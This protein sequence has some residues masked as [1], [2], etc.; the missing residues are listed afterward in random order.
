M[1]HYW[2]NAAFV[3]DD[4]LLRNADRLAGIRVLM[5]H[6]QLD[7]SGPLDIA[8]RLS[9]LLPDSELVVIDD[10]GHGGGETMYDVIVA[11]TDRFAG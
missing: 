11:A 1:T 6:G 8:W 3:E 4:A 2:S 5:V 10:E 9:K 7:I